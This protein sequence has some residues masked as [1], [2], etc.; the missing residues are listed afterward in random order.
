MRH[1]SVVLVAGLAAG[2][3]AIGAQDRAKATTFEPSPDR[4]SFVYKGT[5]FR[6]D[7]SHARA[8]L[9]DWLRDN[10]MCPNGYKER[11]ATAS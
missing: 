4:T 5:M 6:E 1:A 10:N 8:W 7:D 11:F 3:S 9:D 2:C